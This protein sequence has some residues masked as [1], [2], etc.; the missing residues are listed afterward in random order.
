MC[1]CLS[2]IVKFGNADRLSWRSVCPLVFAKTATTKFW[3]NSASK[4]RWVFCPDYERRREVIEVKRDLTSGIVSLITFC[5]MIQF[6]SLL[7]CWGRLLR[8]WYVISIA[9]LENQRHWPLE[10][11]LYDWSAL[12]GAQIPG[13]RPGKSV[14]ESVLI[15]FIGKDQ[16]RSSAV[17]AILKK[18][19]PEAM[20]S[21]SSAK[22]IWIFLFLVLLN[23]LVVHSCF[24]LDGE[25]RNWCTQS[26][27]QFWNLGLKLA[28]CRS[29]GDHWRIQNTFHPNLPN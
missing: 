22:S 1:R 26:H 20:S 24:V 29:L 12:H 23:L 27:D 10:M 19:L 3:R 14:P 8:L 18:T 9:R 7:E 16:I 28:G 11:R 13:F 25:L 4:R 2:I 5:R 17:E 6:I 21:V 15:N